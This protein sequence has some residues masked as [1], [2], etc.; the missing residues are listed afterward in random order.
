M[1]AGA[2]ERSE[3]L[4]SSEYWCIWAVRPCLAAILYS[5]FIEVYYIT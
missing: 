1:P 5:L 4:V 2:R 3:R